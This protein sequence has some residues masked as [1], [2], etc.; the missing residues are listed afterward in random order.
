M[1]PRAETWDS[2]REVADF[3]RRASRVSEKR[4][5]RRFGRAGDVER[6]LDDGDALLLRLRSNCRRVEREIALLVDRADEPGMRDKVHTLAQELRAGQCQ[7][8]RLNVALDGLR[9]RGEA[10][11]PKRTPARAG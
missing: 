7:L 9:P 3:A 4:G 2:E 5:L 10:P 8:Q 1:T 6:I 11:F